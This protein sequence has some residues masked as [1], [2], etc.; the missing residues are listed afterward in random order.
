MGASMPI[1]LSLVHFQNQMKSLRSPGLIKWM[2]QVCCNVKVQVF[3]LT[4]VLYDNIGDWIWA[5]LAIL[6]YSGCGV[7]R[8]R[9]LGRRLS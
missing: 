9:N 8:D 3:I 4:Q 7:G 6:K 2:S 1:P 5:T